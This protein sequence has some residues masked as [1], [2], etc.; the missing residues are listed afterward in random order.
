MACFILCQDCGEIYD[1]GDGTHYCGTD[2]SPGFCDNCGQHGKDLVLDPIGGTYSH[3]NLRYCIK[4]LRGE[5]GHE[6]SHNLSNDNRLFD[7]EKRLSEFIDGRR[8][9]VEATKEKILQ[10]QGEDSE[11]S[12]F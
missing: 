5:I 7:L 3:K 1:V 11:L 12:R 4:N 10:T 2:T 9:A 6:E 8:A